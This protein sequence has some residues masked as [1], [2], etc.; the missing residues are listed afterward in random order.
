MAGPSIMALGPFQFEA[1]G[2]GFT[3][4]RRAQ[5]TKW[6][7]LSVSGGMDRSQWT[8]GQ[9]RTERIGGVIFSEFGGQNSLDGLKLAARNGVPLPLVDLSGN[10]DNVFGIHVIEGV[11]ED[12]GFIDR[13]G[14]A[15]RN[16]YAIRLRQ[17]E[18][19]LLSQISEGLSVI[20]LLT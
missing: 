18:G 2:F 6:A 16:A 20:S 1:R 11:S 13:N 10:L 3:G 17:Y 5:E 7:S 19:G 15:L 8:G 9:S 14:R 12:H 4:R